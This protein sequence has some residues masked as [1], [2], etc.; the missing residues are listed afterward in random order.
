[1]NNLIFANIL[2]LPIICSGL[3]FLFI[4]L[5]DHFLRKS[6]REKLRERERERGMRERAQ[7]Y[8]KHDAFV[9]CIDVFIGVL[10][11][12]CLCIHAT[13]YI[14]TTLVAHRLCKHLFLIMPCTNIKWDF[15]KFF[16]SWKDACWPRN[17]M[18][19]SYSH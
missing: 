3:Y 2:I 18:A 14:A 10:S 12:S 16:R 17:K 4:F 5:D 8:S 9:D 11:S 19:E 6:V 13:V 1:M 7:R 15:E